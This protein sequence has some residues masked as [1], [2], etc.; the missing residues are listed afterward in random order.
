MENKNISRKDPVTIDNLHTLPDESKTQ[1]MNKNSR[2]KPEKIKDHTLLRV[3]KE[4][5]KIKFGIFMV[6]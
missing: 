5:K 6:H 4:A 2:N 3:M 1:T